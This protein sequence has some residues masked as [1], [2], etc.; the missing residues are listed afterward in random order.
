MTRRGPRRGARDTAA[1]EPRRTISA[2]AVSHRGRRDPGVSMIRHSSFA[3]LPT[4]LFAV[5]WTRPVAAQLQLPPPHVPITADTSATGTTDDGGAPRLWAA[6]HR[7]KVRFHDGVTF[8]PRVGAGA[9]GQQVR[10]RTVGLCGDAGQQLRA[11]PHAPRVDAFHYELD[12]GFATE[13]YDV[14]AEGL[15]QSFVLRGRPALAGDLQLV[16]AIDGTLHA[17]PR[18]SAHAPIALLDTDGRQVVRYGAA[19]AIDAH[20]TRHALTTSSDGSTIRIDLPG[21][22]LAEASYPLVVDPLLASTVVVSSDYPDVRIA[23]TTANVQYPTCLVSTL[24]WSATE[25]DVVTRLASAD[26]STTFAVDWTGST[27]SHVE[28]IDVVAARGGQTWTIAWASTA[29]SFCHLLTRDVTDTSWG[30]NPVQLGHPVGATDRNPRLGGSLSGSTP[31][32][33]VVCE[34]TSGS[35]TSIA[36]TLFDLQTHFVTAQMTLAGGTFSTAKAPSVSRDAAGLQWVVAWQSS[37]TLVP[38]YHVAC[39]RVGVAG[40]VSSAALTSDRATLPVHEVAPQVDGRGSHFLLT[41]GEID[42]GL[43]AGLPT[44]LRA[45]RVRSRRFEWDVLGTTPAPLPSQELVANAQ[46]VLEAPALAHDPETRSHW[47]CLVLDTATDELQARMLGMTGRVLRNETVQT[48]V[49]AQVPVR[50][51]VAHDPGHHWFQTVYSM[52]ATYHETWGRV[53]T[54]PNDAVSYYGTPAC[55]S[56][57]ATVGGRWLRGNEYASLRLQGA[58]PDQIALLGL[59]LGNSSLPLDAVGFTGCQLLVDVGA[60]WIQ[61]L[62]EV[63]NAS[64]AAEIVVPLPESIPVA[65]LFAQWLYVTPGANPGNALTTY[66][67][68]LRIR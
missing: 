23:Y 28:S 63:T 16:G 54:H 55:G 18:P 32:V 46:A 38:Q 30:G 66:G 21:S 29:D 50:A 65:D 17:A 8:D 51:A 31:N 4:V 2:V 1:M 20:G 47:I 27:N 11:T 52:R 57:N 19:F 44:S 40:T 3:V 58:S 24:V 59:S 42:Q 33:L 53:A 68:Q 37:S 13:C 10:W 14:L 60:G 49:G 12:V 61:S 15:E 43:V 7:Y 67:V 64:G 56:A 5:L 36:G 39:K 9:A 41:Y 25:T 35:T 22:L 62:V 45:Q 34:R 26:L 48:P 6:G